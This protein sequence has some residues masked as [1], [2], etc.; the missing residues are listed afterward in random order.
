MPDPVVLRDPQQVPEM[1]PIL[2]AMRRGTTRS[3]MRVLD[4]ACRNNHRLAEVFGAGE[5]AVLFVE[6]MGAVALH[7]VHRPLE[8]TLSL[9][10]QCRCS[11]SPIPINWIERQLALGRRRA[12]W[13]PIG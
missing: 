1:V 13:P 8:E 3:R 7:E 5:H 12:I 6:G 9:R 2:N 4:I 11:T 10:A